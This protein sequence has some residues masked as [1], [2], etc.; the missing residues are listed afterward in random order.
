[1]GELGRHCLGLKQRRVLALDAFVGCLRRPTSNGLPVDIRSAS[2]RRENHVRRLALPR[3]SLGGGGSNVYSGRH[4]PAQR[5][6]SAR[7]EN[8]PERI[9]DPYRDLLRTCVGPVTADLYNPPWPPCISSP[10]ERA[11]SIF[12]SAPADHVL[13]YLIAD[14]TTCRDRVRQRNV[15]QPEGVFFGVVTDALL[16][17]VNPY[18]VPPAE[19]ERFNVI[20]RGD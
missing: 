16:D 10:V 7:R 6:P 2:A 18:F 11:R 9:F 12:E 20:V 17:E 15:T 8:Q 3:R 14:E 1:L 19:A 4:L 13:H 5:G